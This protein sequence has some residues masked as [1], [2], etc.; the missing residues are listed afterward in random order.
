MG[1]SSPLEYHVFA[2]PYF[3]PAGFTLAFDDQMLVGYAH[4]GFGP[5]ADESALST[6]SGVLCAIGV[7]PTH[8]RRGIGSELLSRSEAYLAGR[9]AKTLRAGLRYP[10]NPFYFGLYGGADLPGFLATD[11]LA[12]PFLVKHGYHVDDTTLVL[13]R[14]LDRAVNVAD[15]RFANL[16][17]LYD[18]QIVPRPG[19]STWWEECTLGPTE[20][21]ACCL[22]D[23]ASHQV[24]AR[25]DLWEM[26]GFRWRWNESPA[27]L[28]HLHVAP[29]L[30]R[31]G[32]AKF[33]LSQVMRWLQDQYFNLVEIQVP[34]GNEAA[35]KLVRGLAFEQVDI[36]RTY[37]K[38]VSGLPN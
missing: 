37:V 12:D 10:L 7:K 19:I 25:V 4:A 16:R 35:T 13:Q 34:A 23:K 24:V 2:K 18:I 5:N 9:G 30:R 22:E 11:A 15:G 38:Q 1:H 27:G 29:E 26:E 8:R 6:E 28:L 31:Q 3:D 20:L 32:L 36:G 17:R 14:R 21:L 33:L